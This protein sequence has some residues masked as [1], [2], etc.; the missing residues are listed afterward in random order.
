MHNSALRPNFAAVY[1]G[2]SPFKGWEKVNKL[3]MFQVMDISEQHGQVIHF[4]TSSKRRKLQ[5]K[6]AVKSSV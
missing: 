3:H 4:F 6:I 2:F 1:N 5:Q